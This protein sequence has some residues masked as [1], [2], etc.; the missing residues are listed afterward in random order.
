LDDQIK[1]DLEWAM[2]CLD[3]LKD[4]CRKLFWGLFEDGRTRCSPG[5]GTPLQEALFW[6]ADYCETSRKEVRAFTKYYQRREEE[7]ILYIERLQAEMAKGTYLLRD[8]RGRS[9]RLTL[10]ADGPCDASLPDGFCVYE[11]WTC[12]APQRPLYVG[13][14]RHV[15]KRLEQHRNQ[16][17][18]NILSDHASVEVRIT[19][20]ESEE[21]ALAMERAR[22]KA[23]S[24]VYPSL[25]NAVG[26]PWYSPITIR[27]LPTA[28]EL[29]QQEVTPVNKERT[30]Q[31]VLPL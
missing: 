26:N 18:H 20:G 19:W 16:N 6:F 17:T 28:D 23:L 2:V 10:S 31:Q 8:L 1:T 12:E 27:M 3:K 21:W 11:F 13:Q 7:L 9:E 24:E 4:E 22:I 5:D 14:S 30:A 15:R 29:F 25:R